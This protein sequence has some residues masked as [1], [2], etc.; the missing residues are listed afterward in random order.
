M[1][2][3]LKNQD[4]GPDFGNNND[5]KNKKKKQTTKQK[6]ENTNYEQSIWNETTKNSGATSLKEEQEI[7]NKVH[8]AP[9]L[10]LPSDNTKVKKPVVKKKGKGKYGQDLE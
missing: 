2:Y 4:N 5:K 6:F 3:R 10:T 7:F 9:N 1:G 8:G